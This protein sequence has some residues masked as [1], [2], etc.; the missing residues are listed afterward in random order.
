MDDPQTVS[1][2]IRRDVQEFATQWWESM[3]EPTEDGK[4]RKILEIIHPEHFADFA[5]DVLYQ[6]G[7]ARNPRDE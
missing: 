1:P 3:I 5:F 2:P 4:A 6:F 7:S